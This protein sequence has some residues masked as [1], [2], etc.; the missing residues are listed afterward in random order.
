MADG[1]GYQDAP[2]KTNLRPLTLK[3]YFYDKW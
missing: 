3:I 2:A 1:A